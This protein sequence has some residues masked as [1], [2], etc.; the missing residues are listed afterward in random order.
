MVDCDK[1]CGEL[2]LFVVN[3]DKRDGELGVKREINSLVLARAIQNWKGELRLGLLNYL[4]L[5]NLTLYR[6]CNRC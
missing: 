4:F 2:P 3:R 6:M 5:Y 1:R